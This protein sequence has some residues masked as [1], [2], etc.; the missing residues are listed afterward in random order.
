[1]VDYHNDPEFIYFLHHELEL[2]HEHI[3]V[4][5]K[6]REV[7]NGPLPMLLWQYGLVSLEQL[8][9]IFDWLESKN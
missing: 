1:M 4:A 5:I 6:K 3:A 2:P 8:E 7:S 9:R